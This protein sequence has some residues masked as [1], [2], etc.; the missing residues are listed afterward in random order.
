MAPPDFNP[1]EVTPRQLT[2]SRVRVLSFVVVT[3]GVAGL[4]MADLLWGMP[5]A[6]WAVVVWC[7]FVV[8][9]ALI[10]FGFAQAW[11]G[12]RVRRRG[13]DQTIDQTL[14]VDEESVP[15]ASTAIVMPIYNEDVRRVYAGL[16]ATFESV[17]RT[18]QGGWFDFFILSDSTDPN[19][20]VEEEMQWVELSRE[21]NARGRLFYRR[22]RVHVNKKAG[23]IADF[24][25]RWG[26][27]YRYFV[28]LDADSVMSGDTLV[29]LVRMMEVNPKAGLIQTAPQ[30]VRGETLFARVLQFAARLY[31]PIF[32][33]GLNYWQQG[34]GNY[35]GHN[36]IIR[37]APFMAHCALPGLPGREPLG[38]RILSHDFVEAALLRKAGWAV[39]L[40]P[41]ATGTYEEGPANV[42]DYAKR[43]RRWCQGNLQHFWILIARKLHGVSR[44]HLTLGIMAYSSSLLWLLSLVLGTL[45]AIGF[46]FTGLSWLPMPGL[47][48]AV[49]VGHK[50][51]MGLLA[52]FTMVLLFGPKVL[53]VLDQLRQPEGA[54][55]YGGKRALVKSVLMET[56]F[57]VLL[58]PVLM[59]FHSHFV[60]AIMMG[61]GVQW[62]TQRRGGDEDATTDWSE[63]RSVLAGHTCT[64]LIWL[65]L[66]IW[67]APTLMWWM[68]PLLIGLIGSIP[69]AVC[70]GRI[71]WGQAAFRRGWFLIPEETNPPSELRDLKR[72]I[73]HE[74]P[75]IPQVGAG[76]DEGFV[77]VLLDPYVNAVHRCL[78]RERKSRA[79]LFH[80][81]FARLRERVLTEGPQSLSARE[82]AALLADA[83]SV[84]ELHL[85]VWLRQPAGMAACWRQWLGAWSPA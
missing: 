9:F 2:W 36:A 34:E 21:L 73:A 20:W 77:C 71:G 68:A 78:L 60:V 5:L 4:L 58:A 3:T 76:A 82:K 25:R 79:P 66:L 23:N 74:H 24:C 64:G 72:L 48:G 30:L 44:V 85:A 12:Y 42:I 1:E 54:K 49:G 63:A 18:G 29:R 56:L 28:V 65:G 55:P 15:M 40:W 33:E 32:R 53:A 69:F 84:D 46:N 10:A 52:G 67:L 61:R 22:R 41:G 38:G 26:R 81:Y 27:R 51:Q 37:T 50:L 45:L 16:R 17:Q 13:D 43:D 39:W 47:A 57:S 59:L 7:L 11:F 70:S 8:L 14:P 35:W 31:G 75:A 83:T 19:R 80:G 62:V 6:G